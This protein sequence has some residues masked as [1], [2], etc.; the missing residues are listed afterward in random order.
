MLIWS[1]ACVVLWMQPPPPAVEPDPTTQPSSPVSPLSSLL[2]RAPT[3]L[4]SDSEAWSSVCPL[5]LLPLWILYLLSAHTRGNGVQTSV[6]H[7]LLNWLLTMFCLK[8]G[9]IFQSPEKVFRALVCC[10][11]RFFCFCKQDSGYRSDILLYGGNTQNNNYLCLAASSVGR[12]MRALLLS[13]SSWLVFPSSS[14]SSPSPTFFFPA[15]S[16]FALISPL[17]PLPS[18]TPSSLTLTQQKLSPRTT[19]ACRMWMGRKMDNKYETG[20]CR[21]KLSVLIRILLLPDLIR[22][23]MFRAFRGREVTSA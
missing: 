15:S 1:R 22:L 2:K 13:A 17:H 11:A 19:K 14:L 3:C 9:L 18:W 10:S 23:H 21:L 8:T 7:S 4:F 20:A 6:C 12:G 16:Y 5:F